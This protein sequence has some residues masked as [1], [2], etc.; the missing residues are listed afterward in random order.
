[1]FLATRQRLDPTAGLL[2][3][4]HPLEEVTGVDG[5]IVK[6][7]EHLDQLSQREVVEEGG[8]LELDANPA[9]DFLRRL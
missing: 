5:P 7:R 4:A 6:G 9:L 1:M 3:Q 8:R 2:R